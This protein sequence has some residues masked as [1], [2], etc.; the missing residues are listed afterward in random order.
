MSDGRTFPAG[1]TVPIS[2]RLYSAAHGQIVE[3][4]RRSPVPAR[5]FGP[6]KGSIQDIEVW[7]DAHP[8]RGTV[9][10]ILPAQ[11][12]R[13]AAPRTADGVA[14]PF[15]DDRVLDIPDVFMVTLADAR[16]VLPTGLIVTSDDQVVEQACGWGRR[17]YPSDLAYNSLR[18]VLHPVRV[19]GRF[20]TVASRS[21]RNYYHWFSE[22]LTRLCLWDEIPDLPFVFPAPLTSWQRE[23]LRLAGLADERVIE[24][25][26]GC[27]HFDELVFPT[28][29]GT[30]GHL[31]PGV[32]AATRRRMAGEGSIRPE[33]RL[34]VSRRNAAHRRILNEDDLVS[35]LEV[36]GFTC[37]QGDSMT[38]AEQIE[39]FRDAEEVV[40]AHG[41][42]LSN[43][44]FAPSGTRVVEALDPEHLVSC[45]YLMAASLGQSYSCVTAENVSVSRNEPV[46]KGYSDL[47]IPVQPFL[48]L[49]AASRLLAPTDRARTCAT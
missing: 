7:A 16:L 30:V 46:A 29:P 3:W 21:G 26:P 22:C 34:Y 24:M 31:S 1:A 18:P 13:M 37:V 10:R 19:P 47:I 32:L 42:G 2:K 38:L 49:I 17:F 8:T 23:S 35:G 12:H 39:L 43:L 14:P 27:Y 28:F 41:A 6:A 25:E 40:G 33:K 15:A 36:E 48:D 44:L 11:H 20:A 5:W 4:M 45:Y 9:G